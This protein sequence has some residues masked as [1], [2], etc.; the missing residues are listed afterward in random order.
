L[1][2]WEVREPGRRAF[3]CTQVVEGS[4]NEKKRKK[5]KRERKG[6]GTKSIFCGEDMKWE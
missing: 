3:N 2:N 4:T 1:V 5:R 6:I